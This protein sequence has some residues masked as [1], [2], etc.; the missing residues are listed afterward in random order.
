MAISWYT[1]PLTWYMYREM[2]ECDLT[3]E[4]CTFKNQLFRNW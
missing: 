1:Y 4:Q 2:P 3:P